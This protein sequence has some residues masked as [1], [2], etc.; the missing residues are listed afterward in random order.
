MQPLVTLHHFAWP[1][2]IESRGGM[3]SPGFPKLFARYAS[4]VAR[5]I[6]RDVRLWDT[7]NE[8]TVLIFGYLKPWWQ[9]EYF[10]PPGST[11]DLPMGEQIDHLGK[12]IRNLFLAHTAARKA[13]RAV[14]PEALVG[15][16]PAMLG[17]PGWAT[18]LLDWIMTRV[19]F[20][21]KLRRNLGRMSERGFVFRTNADIVLGALTRTAE[22]QEKIDFS[23]NYLATDY[24][25]LARAGQ[26]AAT[27]ARI[28]V[29]KSSTGEKA[30]R[31]AYPGAQII[32]CRGAKGALSALD[33]GKVDAFMTDG[34]LADAIL[35]RLP[36][37]VPCRQPTG[38]RGY[39]CGGSSKRQLRM[40]ACRQQ[41]DPGFHGLRRAGEERP[42][43]F[44][45]G[46]E[47]IPAGASPRE[48]KNGA[49]GRHDGRSRTAA[50]RAA[51][52][53]A[54]RIPGGGCQE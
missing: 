37:A 22:R 31:G 12:L 45:R 14:N 7:I 47:R 2:W 18:S 54:P 32:R 40:A 50:L 19:R 34:L 20:G 49:Y 10:F 27:G 11:R 44:W 29:V 28:A 8:P 21:A 4:V 52:H 42:S 3:A 46:G 53:P 16:N 51:R 5:R 35:N 39:L 38:I 15:T 9:K 33:K 25:L 1:A 24:A 17:L 6:G 26:G 30:A 13:I 41:G 43:A 23:D 48:T 36:G